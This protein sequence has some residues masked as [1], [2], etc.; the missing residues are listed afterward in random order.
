MI[1]TIHNMAKTYKLLPTEVMSR[2]STFD[3]YVL[4]TFHRYQKFIDNK[5]KT[6]KTAPVARTMSKEEMQAMIN[7]VKNNPRKMER[8]GA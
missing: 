3:L 8:K 6:N 1:L 4:D 2:A 5:N 7:H